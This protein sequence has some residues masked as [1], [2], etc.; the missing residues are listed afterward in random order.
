MIRSPSV[1]D[2]VEV[3]SGDGK[4]KCVDAA[5]A[6]VPFNNEIGRE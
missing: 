5:E 4:Q 3:G 1:K 6:T 2:P